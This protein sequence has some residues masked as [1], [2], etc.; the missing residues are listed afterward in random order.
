M[1]LQ[2]IAQIEAFNA[3]RIPD[4]LQLKYKNMRE[5]VFKFYRGTAHL[6]YQHLSPKDMLYQSPSVWICG[7]LHFENF[8]SFKGD[9]G[10]VYFDINDFDQAMLAPCFFD[11]ARFLVSLKLVTGLSDITKKDSDALCRLFLQ[12]YCDTLLT[13]NSRWVEKETAKAVVKKLL[14]LVEKNKVISEEYSENGNRRK[15]DFSHDKIIKP[16]KEDKAVIAQII[17]G[18]KKQNKSKSVYEVVDIGYHLKGTGSLGV[19]RYILLVKK[20]GNNKFKLIDLKTANPSSAM[21][22]VKNKQPKWQSEA[23]RIIEIQKRVQG[24]SQAL[25][26]SIEL[27]KR[28]YV[29]REYQSCEDKIDYKLLKGKI[30]NFENVITTMAQV[31][32]WGQLQSG[33]RQ[34]SA[35]T[36]ELI[37]F[38]QQKDKW[39][40]KLLAYTD[41]SVRTVLLDYD[42]YCKAFDKGRF[43]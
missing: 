7:D 22:A 42:T 12:V 21:L 35:I 2:T 1:S 36:D 33:G 37:A 26:E 19:G 38:A 16:T 25:L 29:L 18:W 28:S 20:I 17:D 34:G 13:G 9:N 4:L 27:N 41:Q 5:D 23:V 43:K 31:T 32:A 6:F 30:S 8:G 24:T 14:R 15:L 39:E 3:G 10:L 40:K 11:V